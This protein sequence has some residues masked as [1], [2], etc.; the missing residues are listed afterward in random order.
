MGIKETILREETQPVLWGLALDPVGHRHSHSTKSCVCAQHHS[1]LGAWRILGLLG[2]RGG[3]LPL[4]TTARPA[5][6]AR[7]SPP[8]SQHVIREVG[9]QLG[10]T[11]PWVDHVAQKPWCRKLKK[12]PASH[13]ANPQ[14]CSHQTPM[15]R[16][17]CSGGAQ[18]RGHEP[19]FPVTMSTS[20][21]APPPGCGP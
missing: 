7:L 20:T 5:T 6:A 19:G 15:L 4:E 18:P 8:R 13:P 9:F 3:K 11:G 2:P 14:V 21:R 12:I 1:C 16:R 10:T 17:K